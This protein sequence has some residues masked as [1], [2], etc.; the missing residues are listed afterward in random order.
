[1]CEV[2][3][4]EIAHSYELDHQT[5]PTDPMSYLEYDGD[6]EFQDEDAFCGEFDFVRAESAATYAATCR[7]RSSSS[8]QRL[9]RAGESDGGSDCE[10]HH[11]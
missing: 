8:P 11:L 1:M 4:Q 5:L 3:A 9:G 7:T 10:Q 2:M 6:R